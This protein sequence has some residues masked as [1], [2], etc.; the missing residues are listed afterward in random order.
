MPEDPARSPDESGLRHGVLAGVAAY[1]IWG[2][3]PLYFHRLDE[4][5]ALEILSHRVVWSLVVTAVPLF[6]TRLRGRRSPMQLTAR[7]VGPLAAAAALIALNWLVYVWAVNHGYVVE[8]ALGYFINP[9]VTVGLGVVVLR[10]QLRRAQWI[11]VGFGAAAV[12]V[13]THAY[14]RPPVISLVLATSFAGYGFFK[15][16]IPLAALESLFAET[17]ILAPVAIGTMA[18]LYANGTAVFARAGNASMSALLMT[19][20][21][22]TA[23]PL[24]LFARSARRIPLTMLGL[25]QYLTPVGQFLCGVLV[26]HERLS[27]QRWV[28]FALVWVALVLLGADA[29]RGLSDADGGYRSPRV[30]GAR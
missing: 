29:F 14:G 7:L 28:G 11:A 2:L 4:A 3:F 27:P 20:G 5:S 17:A 22:V 10:E 21:P 23:V 26:F 12:A 30:R 24:V 15:K 8:A 6:I 13:L 25:L 16:Q 18:V 1:S 9:L 19:A